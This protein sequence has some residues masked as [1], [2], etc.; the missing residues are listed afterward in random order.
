LHCHESA[1]TSTNV[2]ST[3]ESESNGC[4]GRMDAVAISVASITQANAQAKSVSFS[5]EFED[6]EAVSM[7]VSNSASNCS[8]VGRLSC[9]CLGS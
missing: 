8:M 1:V 4:L 2:P 9:K 5:S 7:T 6:S 3:V